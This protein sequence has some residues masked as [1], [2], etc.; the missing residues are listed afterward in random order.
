MPFRRTSHDDGVWQMANADMGVKVNL[1]V[2]LLKA[3][4]FIKGKTIYKTRVTSK[5]SEDINIYILK[6]KLKLRV[7][8]NII[9]IQLG[10]VNIYKENTIV[11]RGL[12]L[13]YYY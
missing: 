13:L 1:N 11:L 5:C 4:A 3:K 12:T 10:K 2:Y 8:K 6:Q 9:K 7:S